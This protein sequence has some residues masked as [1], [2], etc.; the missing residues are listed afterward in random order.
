[1]G[2]SE[3]GWDPFWQQAFG[4]WAAQ[5]C[6]PARVIEEHRGRYRIIAAQREMPAAVS[7][8]LRHLA[9]S[10]RDFPAVGDW[11]AAEMGNPAA[12]GIIHGVLPR[13]SAF[14]RRA[15]GPKTEE[16]LLAA[17]VDTV[18]LVSGLDGDFKPRRIERYL[19]LACE[20]GAAPV[21]V[22]NKAERCVDRE[23]IR[24]LTEAVAGGVPIL[25]ASAVTGEGVEAI[26]DHLQPGMTGVLLGSS[27]VGKSTLI[28]VLLGCEVLKTAPVRQA[29][30]R[31]RHT[32][33][34]RQLIQLP[35]GAML[36]DTPGM[37]E[38]QLLGEEESL[39]QSFGDIRELAEACRFRDCSHAGEPGCVVQ[40]AL[41]DGALEPERYESYLRQQKELRHHQREQD[42]Q[43]QIA[44]KR[45]WKSIHRSMRRQPKGNGEP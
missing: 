7:G 23:A 41:A 44:E 12:G 33:T 22:L 39:G 5:G 35:N 3:L 13:R 36:I 10:R 24:L 6:L 27:G 2:V 4:P 1:M 11:V 25:F 34:H 15:A 16:Q 17:N 9:R 37:R 29:D 32:T 28:N 40:Q 21:I 38:L 31:G 14:M 26:G 43:L 20:S 42:I 8:R 18:F 19:T 30:S 45:R